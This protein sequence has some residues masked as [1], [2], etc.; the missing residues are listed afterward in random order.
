M[1]P[2]ID[3]LK[4]YLAKHHPKIDFDYSIIEKTK[5]DQDIILRKTIIVENIVEQFFNYPYEKKTQKSIAKEHLWSTYMEKSAPNPKYPNDWQRRKELA[6]KRDNKSCN[7]CGEEIS[8]KNS[9]SCFVRKIEDSGSY[10][11]EN[12][13]TLC[14]DCNKILNSNNT[15]NTMSSL[16][17]NDKLL[18]FVK[19]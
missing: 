16:I 18:N 7:R 11:F 15:K 19:N 13:I 2:F 10:S 5:N 17:L 12:I 4:S 6:W 8:L 1:S 3:D 14:S 9:Y